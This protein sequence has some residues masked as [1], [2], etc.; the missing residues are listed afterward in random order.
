MRHMRKTSA[1][2]EKLNERD[3]TTTKHV[4]RLKINQQTKKTPEKWILLGKG[5]MNCELQ[6]YDQMFGVVKF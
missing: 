6:I 4:T 2:K 1:S 5:V 3:A